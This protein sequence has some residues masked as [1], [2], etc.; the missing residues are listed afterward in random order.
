[1]GIEPR[2]SEIVL[3]ET[4]RQPYSDTGFSAGIVEG[5]SIDTIYLKLARNG[6]EPTTILFRRDEA[7]AVVWLLSGALWSEAMHEPDHKPDVV[8]V[9]RDGYEFCVTCGTALGIPEE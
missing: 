7:L 8:A 5:H 6:E 9:V 4:G 2:T 3:T 1:M